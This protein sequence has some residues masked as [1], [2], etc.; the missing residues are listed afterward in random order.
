VTGFAAPY[1][2]GNHE[3]G[4]T[5]AA[6]VEAG[7][8]ITPKEATIILAIAAAIILRTRLSSEAR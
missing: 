6:R 2:H 7:K 8:T 1:F 4:G 5:G 3:L